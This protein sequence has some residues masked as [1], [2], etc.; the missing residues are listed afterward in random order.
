[1]ATS[2]KSSIGTIRRGPPKDH[3]PYRGDNP[4]VGKKTGIRVRHVERKS[5]GFEPFQEILEQGDTLTPPLLK[6][7]KKKRAVQSLPDDDEYGEMSMEIDDS[8]CHFV[9]FTQRS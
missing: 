4:E 5:D 7:R 6:A 9:K 2:R 3:L 8:E 1:M